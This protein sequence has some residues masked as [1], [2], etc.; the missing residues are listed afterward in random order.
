MN[1]YPPGRHSTCAGVP[2]TASVPSASAMYGMLKFDIA[3]FS[4]HENCR[5]APPDARNVEANSYVLSCS[6]TTVRADGAS[7][8]VK[9]ATADPITPPPTIAM[10]QRIAPAGDRVLAMMKWIVAAIIACDDARIRM[11]RRWLRA[12]FRVAAANGGRRACVGVACRNR[13][14]ARRWMRARQGDGRHC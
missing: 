3:M 1:R 13:N 8:R 6:S 11:E 2:S 9:Y 5:R 10:S 4:G 14:G 7:T 12:N